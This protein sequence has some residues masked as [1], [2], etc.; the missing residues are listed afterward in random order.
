MQEKASPHASHRKSP[1][2]RST[3]T[4]NKMIQEA[5]VLLATALD[6]MET[7]TTRCVK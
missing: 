7:F 5:V 4:M 6:V 2:I 1:T 3:M